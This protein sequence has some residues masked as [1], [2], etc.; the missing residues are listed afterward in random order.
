M[1][2]MTVMILAPAVLGVG[3]SYFISRTAAASRRRADSLAAALDRSGLQAERM[4]LI[5]VRYA[6]RVAV[7][8]RAVEQMA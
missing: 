7:R 3:V 1:W 5:A 2:S 8:Q 6:P 4:S